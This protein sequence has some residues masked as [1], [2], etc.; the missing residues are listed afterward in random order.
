AMAVTVTGAAGFAGRVGAIQKSLEPF[1]EALELSPYE[2]DEPVEV[3]ADFFAG[4]PQ[5]MP[6]PG[7]VAALRKWIEPQNKDWFAYKFPLPETKQAAAD[8][9]NRHQQI[10]VEADDILPTR[11]AFGAL[12][13]CLSTVVD[14]GDEVIYLSPPWFFYEAMILAVD[15]RPVGV[16]ARPDTF[17]IDIAALAAAIT[18]KTKAIIINTPN[19]PTGKIYPPETLR[20]LGAMLD[21]AGAL[22][23]KPIYIISDES[24]SRILF[25]AAPFETPARHYAYTLLVHTYSKSALAPGQRLGYIA[26]PPSMPGRQEMRKALLTM[27]LAGG[28]G[29]PD[30]VM[31]YALA[32]IDVLSIDLGEL[33]ARRDRMVGELQRIGYQL[34]SPEGAFYLLPKAPIAD[35]MQFARMLAADGV[36]VLPGKAVEMPGYFRISLTATSEMI[37]RGLPVFERAFRQAAF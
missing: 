10:G 28:F 3:V 11:G 8:G 9:L 35:D 16:K 30:T 17:D 36:F 13:I 6:L 37:D 31:Q 32:D 20:Q 1:V 5:Q 33:R 23:G 15:G 29:L 27:A 21:A 4:N 18:P 14:P 7:Y 19:N 24:Y 12:Q 26:V 34:H 22:H 25:G 2:K